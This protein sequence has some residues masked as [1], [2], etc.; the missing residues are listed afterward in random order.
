MVAA[1]ILTLTLKNE[2]QGILPSDPNVVAY[3]MAVSL[4]NQT[5]TFLEARQL[6]P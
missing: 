5:K 3:L 4:Y 2:L 1:K 6:N